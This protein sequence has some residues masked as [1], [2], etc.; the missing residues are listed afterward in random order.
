MLRPFKTSTCFHCAGFRRVSELRPGR[1][2]QQ[3]GLSHGVPLVCSS[4]VS[5][6]RVVGAVS[7]PVRSSAQI[8]LGWQICKIY[9]GFHCL[10][11]TRNKNGV[12]WSLRINQESETQ[13]E[14][15]NVQL[16]IESERLFGDS[17]TDEAVPRPLHCSLRAKHV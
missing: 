16:L 7:A 14:E 9:R 8:A 11:S 6:V 4:L 2:R 12:L 13:V 17:D 1:S 15:P 5:A 10:L 3:I